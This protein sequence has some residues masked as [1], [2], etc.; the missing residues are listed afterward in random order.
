MADRA[1]EGVI[2]RIL[3]GER[4]LGFKNTAYWQER[5][6]WSSG[7]NELGSRGTFCVTC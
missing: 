1:V 4:P 6:L 5:E 2:L 7:E 3:A